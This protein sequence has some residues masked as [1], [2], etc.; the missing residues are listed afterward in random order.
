MP[1]F[2]MGYFHSKI[3][4]AVMVAILCGGICMPF[5]YF[6]YSLSSQ[7]SGFEIPIIVGIFTLSF[8]VSIS[9]IIK[10]LNQTITLSIDEDGLR[11]IKKTPIQTKNIQFKQWNEIEKISRVI[12]AQRVEYNIHYKNSTKKTT[13][14]V[15]ANTNLFDLEN[16][17]KKYFRLEQVKR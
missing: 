14:K 4:L 9:A 15:V 5:I 12:S 17:I 3:S 1:N 10:L 8:L 16:A 11:L 13:L 7:A 2:Q 6:N